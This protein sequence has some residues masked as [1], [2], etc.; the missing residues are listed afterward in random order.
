[1]NPVDE[2]S[3]QL[4]Q[5]LESGKSIIITTIQK[6]PVISDQISKMKDR[7]FGVIIDEVHSSQSGESSR[8][9]KKSLS[10]KSL[11]E[12]QEGEGDGD[13]TDVDKLILD[14]IKERGEQP[15]ISFF[16]FTT[17]LVCSS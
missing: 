13:L 7:K 6:F 15:N 11:D 5:F 9:L 3:Q 10:D 2:T 14:K 8:H 12:F 1:M 4:R 16:G 17:P